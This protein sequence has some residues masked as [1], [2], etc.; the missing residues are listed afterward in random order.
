MTVTDIINAMVT[1]V[2]HT[3]GEDEEDP[4]DQIERYNR[5]R[6]RFLFY[7]WGVFIT[8]YARQNLWSGILECG[9]DYIYAD[10]D[11][12]KVMNFDSHKHYFDDYN[13]DIIRKLELACDHHGIS[14]DK[15]S[16][17]T[18]KGKKKP[19][20]VWDDEGTYSHFKTLGAKRYLVE[21]DGEI[22]CTI[23]GVNKKETSKYIAAQ[24]DPW[25]F[26][27]DQMSV[28]EEHSGRLISTYIDEPY[29]GTVADYRGVC[30][31]FREESGV[32]FEKSDYNLTMTKDFLNLILGSYYSEE[33]VIG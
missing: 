32:H 9:Q 24:E 27:S 22:T 33:G 11:S 13:S 7:P 28:D 10:T 23:A 18:V 1:Y 30:Y 8:A 31:N 3:W 19:L 6:N 14:K 21:H 25:G 12:V 20:G 29:S 26:F 2:G 15:I 16:P 4:E 5:S 17:V